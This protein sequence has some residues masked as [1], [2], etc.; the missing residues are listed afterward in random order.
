M[1]AVNSTPDAGGG[2]FH[3]GRIWRRP[4]YGVEINTE[5]DDRDDA[6][7]GAFWTHFTSTK[8]VM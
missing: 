8:E 1:F 7:A 2:F 6:A 5:A 3:A 4:I